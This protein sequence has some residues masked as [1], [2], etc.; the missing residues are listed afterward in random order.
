MHVSLPGRPVPRTFRSPPAAIQSTLNGTQNAFFAQ[1]DTTTVTGQNRS[2]LLFAPISAAMVSDRGTSIAVDPNLNTYFVGDTTSTNLQ[3]PKSR[4]RP[5]STGPA[6][7]FVGSWGRR[8]ICASPVWRHDRLPDWNGERRQPGHDNLYRRQRRAGPGDEYQGDRHGFANGVTFNSATAGSGTC[9]APSSNSGGLP[10]PH[11][12]IRFHVDS[13]FRGDAESV[14][15]AYSVT[16]TVSSS[17]NTNTSNTATARSPRAV[18][19]CPSAPPAAD[20]CRRSDR[21]IHRGS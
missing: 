15:A 17:N 6:T 18:F 4:C 19:P 21:A 8:R 20:G 14:P 12:A 11:P 9:S 16:A 13:R 7:R 2:R 1:I 10:D 3:V 5:R